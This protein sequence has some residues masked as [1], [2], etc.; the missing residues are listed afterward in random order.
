M[1]VPGAVCA[2]MIGSRVF[3]SPYI[4]GQV[5]EMCQPFQTPRSGG[6]EDVHGGAIKF[7]GVSTIFWITIP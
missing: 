7:I 5:S 3:A 4:Q 1:V 2:W 6:E